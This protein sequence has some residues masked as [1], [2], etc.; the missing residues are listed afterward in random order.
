MINRTR[1]WRRQIFFHFFKPVPNTIILSIARFYL[2]LS[3]DHMVSGPIIRHA[4]KRSLLLAITTPALSSSFTKLK[5]GPRERLD[6]YS[7]VGLDFPH[8]VNFRDV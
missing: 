5:N 7:F 3:R 6:Y 2:V 4:S 1:P 8:E